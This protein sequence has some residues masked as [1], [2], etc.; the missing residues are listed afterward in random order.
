MSERNGDKARFG[1]ERLRKMLRQKQTRES[2]KALDTPK[3]A[4]PAP[5][6]GEAEPASCR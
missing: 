4:R 1:R 3:L 6:P 2:Q 5:G